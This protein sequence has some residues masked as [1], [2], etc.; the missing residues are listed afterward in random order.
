MYEP[1]EVV[2][3]VN[4]EKT[5]VATKDSG[6]NISIKNGSGGHHPGLF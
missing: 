6:R 4:V 2:N 3:V 5:M 1:L